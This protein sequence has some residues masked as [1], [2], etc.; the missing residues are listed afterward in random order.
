MSLQSST[1][2]VS[3]NNASLRICDLSSFSSGC[4]MAWRYSPQQLGSALSI[5]KSQRITALKLQNTTVKRRNN[6]NN[7]KPTLFSD[8]DIILLQAEVDKDI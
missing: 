7:K 5:L 1:A 3:F 2:F 6:N 8:Q 4:V